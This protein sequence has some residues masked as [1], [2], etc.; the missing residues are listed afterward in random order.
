MADSSTELFYTNSVSKLTSIANR[1]MPDPS[2]STLYTSL[3]ATASAVIKSS[4]GTVYSIINA[5]NTA[6]SV[7]FLLLFNATSVPSAGASPLIPGFPVPPN[8]GVLFFGQDIA[9]GGGLSFSAGITVAIS[10]TPFTYT[11]AAASDVGFT[12]KYL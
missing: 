7:R 10:T 4:P 5:L 9:G 3:G 12:I 2:A 1:L 6:S 11:A 8:N